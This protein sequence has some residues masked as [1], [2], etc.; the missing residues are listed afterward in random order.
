MANS[1]RAGQPVRSADELDCA[2]SILFHAPADQVRAIAGLLESACID[3]KSKSLIFCDCEIPA[4]LMHRFRL[5]G[6]SA[7][8]ARQFGMP[9]SVMVEGTGPALA[10]AHRIAIALRLQAIEI[11]PGAGDLFAA[12]ITIA[13]G[14]LTPLINR[15]AALLRGSGLRDKAA[16]NIA[17]ALFEQTVQQYGHSG[18]QSWVWHVRGPA[19]ERMEA[20]IASVEEPFRELFRQLIVS[21]FEDFDKHPHLARIL[22]GP[23]VLPAGGHE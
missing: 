18:K 1:L 10:G 23:D 9:G 8:V 15:A 19:A 3:W 2:S 14:A 4:E 5:L 20:E 11:A 17:T 16:V 6:A 7:A 21:G 22:R 12:A 13:T